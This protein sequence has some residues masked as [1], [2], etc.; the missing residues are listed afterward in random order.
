MP[1]AAF[2]RAAAEAACAFS[3]AV[4]EPCEA[5]GEAGRRPACARQAPLWLLPRRAASLTAL[6]PGGGRL[7]VI[8]FQSH[9]DRKV[10]RR[11]RMATTPV[12][13]ENDPWGRPKEPVRVR[14]LARRPITATPEELERNFRAR[15]AKLRGIEKL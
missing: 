2:W 4:A 10:K 7:A 15:S 13:D 8:T 14:D 3:T 5:S 1:S 12:I 9:E 11:I 6:K